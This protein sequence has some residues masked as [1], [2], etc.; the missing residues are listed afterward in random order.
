MLRCFSSTSSTTKSKKP[1]IGE[2]TATQIVSGTR[3][4]GYQPSTLT[5]HSTHCASSTLMSWHWGFSDAGMPAPPGGYKRLAS[6]A[7]APDEFEPAALTAARLNRFEGA[8]L[9]RARKM[10]ASEKLALQE[11]GGKGG[12]GTRTSRPQ[13]ACTSTRHQTSFALSCPMPHR[14][15]INSAIRTDAVALVKL[16][17]LKDGLRNTSH[18]LEP[19]SN[20]FHC[21]ANHQSDM[22][23]LERW[24]SQSSNNG[25][26]IIELRHTHR[27]QNSEING[28]RVACNAD[29]STPPCTSHSCDAPRR[30]GLSPTWACVHQCKQTRV[31]ACLAPHLQWP[32]KVRFEPTASTR[33][34]QWSPQSPRNLDAGPSGSSC[35]RSMGLLPGATWPLPVK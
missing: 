27:P 9:S 16:K 22:D 15:E 11:E 2:K 6:A 26:T 14:G 8:N 18:C 31:R 32:Q 3:Q 30:T 28:P 12:G 25:C 35:D 19:V 1:R 29:S 13:H 24:H 4:T 7:C 17:E 21:V 5:V 10:C 34:A 20:G 23:K 33:F